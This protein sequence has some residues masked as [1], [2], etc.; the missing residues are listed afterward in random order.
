MIPQRLQGVWN[1]GLLYL[2]G[3]SCFG[4]AD[5]QPEQE[6]SNLV[7]PIPFSSSPPSEER[8]LSSL[9]SRVRCL[10]EY[11]LL[12][13]PPGPFHLS[14]VHMPQAVGHHADQNSR[15]STGRDHSWHF[16]HAARLPELSSGDM[17]RVFV[18]FSF[19]FTI[20][21]QSLAPAPRA[22]GPP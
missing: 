7:N 18:A 16:G 6:R 8:V 21:P 10:L 13:F 11:P 15:L 17:F 5:T 9:L 2:P 4:T 3:W 12:A 19:F 14:T 20:Y 22:F 1:V